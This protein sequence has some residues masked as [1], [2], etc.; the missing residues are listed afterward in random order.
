MIIANTYYFNNDD[1]FLSIF[2]HL[3][4]KVFFIE[5]FLISLLDTMK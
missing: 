3:L 5:N 4:T 2:L 1:L